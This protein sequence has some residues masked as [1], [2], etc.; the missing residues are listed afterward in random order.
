LLRLTTLQRHRWMCC[1]NHTEALSLW[2]ILNTHT[3]TIAQPERHNN[4]AAWPPDHATLPSTWS[5]GRGLRSHG[6]ARGAL[7]YL[8]LSTEV[9]LWRYPSHTCGMSS[10]YAAS[11]LQTIPRLNVFLT[12]NLVR[13]RSL[14]RWY[15]S[16]I[17]VSLDIKLHNMTLY[18]IAFPASKFSQNDCTMWN[19]SYT[20][21]YKNIYAVQL[22]FSYKKAQWLHMKLFKNTSTYIH[23]YCKLMLFTQPLNWWVTF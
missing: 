10:D 6:T 12:G 8:V 2:Y 17:I 22:K 7:G 4:W 15:I 16:T 14:W 23:Q 11:P 1:R 9:A 20:R 3:T 19:V 13:S 5:V 18:C 21:K